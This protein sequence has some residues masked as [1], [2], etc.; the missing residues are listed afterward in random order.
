MGEEEVEKIWNMYLREI[1]GIFDP[2]FEPTTIYVGDFLEG[3]KRNSI[4]A[5]EMTH[6]LQN[7]NNGKLDG[8]IDQTQDMIVYYEMQASKVE[9]E[10]Y[11]KCKEGE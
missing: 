7:Y 5:H 1:I 3:C 8:L 2:R 9:E 10:Y 4:I 11:K 6:Y